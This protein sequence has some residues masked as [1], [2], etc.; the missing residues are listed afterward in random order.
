M[1]YLK[2]DDLGPIYGHQWRSFNAPYINSEMKLE[3]NGIDQLQNII[4]KLSCPK[5][6]HSRRVILS[7]WNPQQ[8]DQIL[9][10]CHIISQFIV[11]QTISL[12]LIKKW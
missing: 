6:R 3:N 10:P 9:P 1:H 7:A 5:E 2:E 11:N 4:N 12:F 8:L